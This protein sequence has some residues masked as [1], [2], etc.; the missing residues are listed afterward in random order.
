MYASA[1]RSAGSTPLVQ[2]W[3]D[4]GAT[5]QR[6]VDVLNALASKDI[7]SVTFTDLVD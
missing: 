4:S 5:Q 3:A 2:L 1:A 6:V 7:Q